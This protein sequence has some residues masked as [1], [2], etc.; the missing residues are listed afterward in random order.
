MAELLIKTEPFEE[1]AKLVFTE[2]LANALNDLFEKEFMTK[3]RPYK[4]DYDVA[5]AVGKTTTPPQIL[6]PFS[7]QQLQAAK[8]GSEIGTV[9]VLGPDRKKWRPAWTKRGGKI[10]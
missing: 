10:M 1:T 7:V 3:Q 8:E 2:S 6:I 5:I 4:A 9:W